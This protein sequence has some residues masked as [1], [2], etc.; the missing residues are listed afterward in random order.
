MEVLPH[1][2]EQ[3]ADVCPFVQILDAPVP[4]MGNQ[5]LEI[6]RHLHTALPEQDIDV[7]K[8]SQDGIQQRFADRDLR[9]PKMAEQLVE[10]PTVLSPSLHQQQIAEQTVDIPVPRGRGDLGGLEG[11]LPGQ[12]SQRTVEQIVDILAGGGLQ[13][14]LPDPQ[15]GSLIR[16]IA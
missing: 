2:V 9:H 3:M 7:P 8:I 12:G 10:V 16:S 5:L 11:F 1:V 15:V 6:F 14:F 4:Q 13:G